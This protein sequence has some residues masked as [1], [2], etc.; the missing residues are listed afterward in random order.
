MPIRR[1]AKKHVIIMMKSTGSGD[2]ERGCIDTGKAQ[3]QQAER[4]AVQVHFCIEAAQ[5]E[6]D[7]NSR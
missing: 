3:P 7:T 6:P 5:G 4:P 1:V 2:H